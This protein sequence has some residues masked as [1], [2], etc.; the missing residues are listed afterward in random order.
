MESTTQPWLTA[1]SKRDY[2]FLPGNHGLN[3]ALFLDA[4]ITLDKTADSSKR[5]KLYAFDPLGGP[6]II[7]RYEDDTLL[8]DSSTAD[9]FQSAVF[10][11]WTSLRWRFG[12]AFVKLIVDSNLLVISSSFTGGT[13]I[14]SPSTVDIRPS[15]LDK[16]SIRTLSDP[17]N[18]PVNI[19]SAFELKAGFNCDLKIADQEDSEFQLSLPEAASPRHKTRI[20]IA[21]IPGAGEGKYV[22]CAASQEILTI[23][24]I[25]PDSRDNF[26]LVGKDCTWAE[27]LGSNNG[28]GFVLTEGAGGGRYLTLHQNCQ[29][30]CQ[31]EDY[32]GLYEL[33]T[34]LW[35]QITDVASALSA[36][37]D[38]YNQIVNS[39][40]SIQTC[41]KLVST[42]TVIPKHDWVMGVQILIRNST[43]CALTGL[44]L[45]VPAF[46]VTGGTPTAPTAVVPGT[47]KILSGGS[48][49]AS[50][51]PTV[52]YQN[53]ALV[54]EPGRF[55]LFT[56][57]T[58]TA[59]ADT[60]MTMTASVTGLIGRVPITSAHSGNFLAPFTK[61]S[62][63]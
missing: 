34:S 41:K 4:A 17:N 40:S 42:L 47:G 22:D 3:Q 39:W 25:A 31:C 58:Y 2:P 26:Q 50:W 8:F 13:A 15:R 16:V 37:K 28:S 57:D 33:L 10:G 21:A 32:W 12:K 56:L 20:S 23:N 53:A 43:G 51:D 5:L 18:T 55:L 6:S 1:N 30:C 29:A 9:N 44:T 36:N 11:N 45:D 48:E 46:G 35:T 63:V 62:S 61:P 49:I 59:G 24:G 38:T 7:I 27:V 54:L 60:S 52:Q 19:T 14:I